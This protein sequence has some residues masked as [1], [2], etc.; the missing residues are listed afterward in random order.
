MP[1]AVDSAATALPLP[2]QP[3]KCFQARNW[4]CPRYEGWSNCVS[5]TELKCHSRRDTA[6]KKL[7]QQTDNTKLWLKLSKKEDAR[8]CCFRQ[9]DE[10]KSL[11][12]SLSKSHK[13]WSAHLINLGQYLP[14]EHSWQRTAR[15]KPLRQ[16]RARWAPRVSGKADWESGKRSSGLK[17]GTKSN[18]KNP[19]SQCDGQAY[20]IQMLEATT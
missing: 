12:S 14:E 17:M 4:G 10:E 1:K 8:L 2:A 13:Q 3:H 9:G 6:N 11:W 18:K 19:Y 16:I 15:A 7:Y 20:G 5:F